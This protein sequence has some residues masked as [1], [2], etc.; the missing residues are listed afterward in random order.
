MLFRS[1]LT[2]QRGERTRL[3]ALRETCAL[4]GVVLAASLPPLVGRSGLCISFVL[5]LL[6]TAFILLRRA[7]RAVLWMLPVALVVSAFFMLPSQ[8]SSRYLIPLMPVVA[9]LCALHIERGAAVFT[10]VCA[11][12]HGTSGDGRGPA[13]AELRDAWDDPCPPVD[14]RLAAYRNGRTAP[15]IFRVLTLGISGP[16]HAS[17]SLLSIMAAPGLILLVPILDTTLVTVS[18]IVSGR[19][20]AQG[21]RDHSSHQIGRAHV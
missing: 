11:A 17:G 14:L 5:L 10:A 2:Q 8:R 4:V 18:R 15:D 16:G 19:S 7:P 21:G 3:T 12:C 9:V 13:A 20:A 1:R 6:L